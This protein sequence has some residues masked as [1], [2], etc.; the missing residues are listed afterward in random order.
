MGKIEEL[1]IVERTV[2]Q[3]KEIETTNNNYL[4]CQ[5]RRKEEKSYRC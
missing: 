4:F 5:Q 1:R 2:K 3:A